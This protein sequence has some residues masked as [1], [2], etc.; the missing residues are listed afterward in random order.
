MMNLYYYIASKSLIISFEQL[1]SKGIHVIYSL[2]PCKIARKDF[3]WKDEDNF[4]FFRQLNILIITTTQTNFPKT[5]VIFI[6]RAQDFEERKESL[7]RDDYHY[8]E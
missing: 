1:Q 4:L 2:S 7:L 3:T 5:R 8:F 6:C